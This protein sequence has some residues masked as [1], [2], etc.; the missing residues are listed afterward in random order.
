M[1]NNLAISNFK[2]FENL[3]IELSNLNVFAGINS[4]GKSSVIQAILLLRQAYEMGTLTKGLHLNGELTQIGTGFD[5][6]YRNSAK[7]EISIEISTDVN[8]YRWDYNYTKDSDYQELRSTNVGQEEINGINIFAP[9]F[10]YVSAERIGPQ[11]YYKQSY[12]EIYEKNQVCGGCCGGWFRENY[13]IDNCMHWLTATDILQ[14]MEIVQ[15]TVMDKFGVMLEPE[16][17]IIGE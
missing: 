16:V 1:I 6:L 7:D 4:M 11:R 15:Q 17:R 13:Y 5:L 9:T 3:S 10:S 8:T 14:L 12:H 2:C